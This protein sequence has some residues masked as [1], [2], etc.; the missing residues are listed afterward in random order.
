[1]CLALD[2]ATTTGWAVGPP[3]GPVALGHF[4]CDMKDYADR[5]LQMTKRISE[6]IDAHAATEVVLEAPYIS[7]GKTKHDGALPL[8]YGFQACAMVAAR[9]HKLPVGSYEAQLI[10]KNFIGAGGLRRADAKAGVLAKCQWLGL[11]PK[12]EDEADACA[13]W[14]Y[15]CS[16][17]SEAHL[18]MTMRR[19]GLG[20]AA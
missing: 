17:I 1:M 14:S 15:R 20:V 12:T 7:H 19:G 3:G 8:L 18:V 16:I 10:R 5:F 13:V 4:R 9:N 2:L 6:L 11:D